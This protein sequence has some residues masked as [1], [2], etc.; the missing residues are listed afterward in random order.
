MFT[1]SWDVGGGRFFRSHRTV[2][3]FRKVIR[4]TDWMPQNMLYPCVMHASSWEVGCG[5]FFSLAP[6]SVHIWESHSLYWLDALEHVISM[7]NEWGRTLLRN[8]GDVWWPRLCIRWQLVYAIDWWLLWLMRSAL[9]WWMQPVAILQILMLALMR[10]ADHT[11]SAS[12]ILHGCQS[13]ASD[14]PY[15]PYRNRV[16]TVLQTSINI[17]TNHTNNTR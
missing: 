2:F 11:A 16:Q 4:T 7:R 15:K 17:F 5:R 10:V 13:Q 14:T 9:C 1:S 12:V 8:W 6:D 3:T